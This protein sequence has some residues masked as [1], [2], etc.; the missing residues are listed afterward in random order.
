MSSFFKW[1]FWGLA[2]SV[3]VLAII[4]L[5]KREEVSR[6]L[7]VNSL[8]SQ[9]KIV[10]NFSNMDA[11]FLTVPLTRAVDDPAPLAQGP[12]PTLP[13]A[14]DKWI[15]T[16]AVTSL[17]VLKDGKIAFED[18]FQGTTSSDLRI[19][20]SVS[21]SYLSALLGVLVSEGAIADLDAPVTDYAPELAGSAYAA[22]SIRNV[23][24]MSSGVTFN[25]DYLDQSSDI[26]RMG[27]VLAL[28]RSMDGFTA[29]LTKTDATPGDRWQYVSID[30]HVIGMIIRGATGRSIVDLLIEK[31]IG[32]MGFEAD[33]YFLTDG[34][35]VAFV[36]GGLNTTTR[37]N[38]RFGQMFAQDGIWEGQQIV[39]A[40]WIA[41]STAPSAN[42][43]DGEIGYGYQWWIPDGATSGQFLARGIYGQYIYIDQGRNVVVATHGA[44]RNFRDDGVADENIAMFR[45]IAESLD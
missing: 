45:A 30:T 7:A 9:A 4:A 8:F 19:N 6:L 38:A 44:D 23:L 41:E 5:I 20:W 39:P 26:N 43:Q 2:L 40:D 29:D 1:V 18:Y 13:A 37:D 10:T 11:A 25:E 16:R 21:K 3:T 17:V 33:P 28:G 36:L 31:I 24:Q 27:R 12:A 14:V 35:G 34:Y 42:T 22:A 32:P 15:G